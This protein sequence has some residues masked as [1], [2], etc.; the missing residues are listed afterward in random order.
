MESRTEHLADQAGAELLASYRT[1]GR[2]ATFWDDYQRILERM[3]ALD[4][5]KARTANRL[6]NIAEQLGV[7][8]KAL[9]V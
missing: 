9:Q 3:A 4:G 6:A 8:E 2:S 1:H 7:V 5:G